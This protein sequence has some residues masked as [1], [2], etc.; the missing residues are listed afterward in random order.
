LPA[1]GQPPLH[2]L[3]MSPDG[4]FVAYGHSCV[5]NAVPGEVR[6]WDLGGASPKVLLDVPEGM[7]LSALSFQPDGRRLAVGH[8]DSSVSIYALANGQRVQRLMVGAAPIQL[9]FHPR[10]GRLAV[11]CDNAVQLFDTDSGEELPALRHPATVTWVAWHPDGRRL[12]TGCSD[13]KI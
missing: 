8:A 6:V 4:R 5:R 10:D 2:G 12:A 13:R 9:V 1:H 7:H 11:A 3:W